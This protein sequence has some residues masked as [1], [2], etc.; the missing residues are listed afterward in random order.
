MFLD[1]IDYFLMGSFDEKYHGQYFT[2]S[3]VAFMDID[4]MVAWGYVAAAV[5]GLA[6]SGGDGADLLLVAVDGLIVA[7]VAALFVIPALR[8][9]K[10]TGKSGLLLH[11]VLLVVS[12]LALAAWSWAMMP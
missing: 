11:L 2:Y 3:A 4:L 10:R 12:S 7:L 6:A 1:I 8:I 5:S 9:R